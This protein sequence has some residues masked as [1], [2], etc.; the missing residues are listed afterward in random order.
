MY[1][2]SLGQQ[3]SHDIFYCRFQITF[4]SVPKF[5]MKSVNVPNYVSKIGILGVKYNA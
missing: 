2:K 5:V 1:S 3:V 4:Q